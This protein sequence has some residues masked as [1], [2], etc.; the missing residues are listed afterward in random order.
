MDLFQ[1]QRDLA[2]LTQRVRRLEAS[3]TKQHDQI[4]LL[5]ND[6][7]IVNAKTQRVGA[8]LTTIIVGSID[9]T[10]TWP[11]PWPDTAYMVAPA[12]LSGTGALG[13]LYATLK[14]GTKT[15][16]DCV[17]TVA[18]TGLVTIASAGLDVLGIRT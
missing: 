18:N 15:V 10:I 11:E 4:I 12:I 6:L 13:S 3:A 14:S 2:Q 9:V 5:G 16:D 8:S 17:V 1:L 7:A